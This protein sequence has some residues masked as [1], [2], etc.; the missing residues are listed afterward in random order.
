MGSFLFFEVLVE[1]IP[2]GSSMG[3]KCCPESVVSV[4]VGVEGLV[5][6]PA[7]VLVVC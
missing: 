2:A 4:V 1:E 3:A 5:G 7:M 6:R